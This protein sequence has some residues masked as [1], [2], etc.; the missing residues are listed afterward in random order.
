M[1]LSGQEQFAGQAIFAAPAFS[2]ECDG[3]LPERLRKIGDQ[4][5]CVL[6]AD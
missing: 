2:S 1:S 4:V 5:V 6:Q 3:R